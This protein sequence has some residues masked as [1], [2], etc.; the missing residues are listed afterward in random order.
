DARR[1]ARP[2][3]AAAG[4]GPGAARRP[5]AGRPYTTV[6]VTSTL[7]RVALEYGHTWWALATRSSA[8]AR[9]GSDGTCTRRSTLML[10]TSPTGP[11]PTRAVTVE[12]SIETFSRRATTPIAPWKQAA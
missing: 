1:P 10:N 3:P 11:R 2:G 4:G 9:S 6:S 12:P 8:A 7:P 5:A